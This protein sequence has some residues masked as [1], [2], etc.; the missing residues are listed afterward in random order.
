MHTFVIITLK[1]RLGVPGRLEGNKPRLT[2]LE[3]NE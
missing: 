3:L 2:V 1:I